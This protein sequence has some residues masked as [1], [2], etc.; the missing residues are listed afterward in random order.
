MSI[1]FLTYKQDI[2]DTYTLHLLASDCNTQLRSVLVPAS[3]IHD[4]KY[5]RLSF[6]KI[7]ESKD[8]TFCISLTV[9]QPKTQTLALALSKENLYEDGV[10]ISDEKPR[11][12]D[13][14][15]RLHYSR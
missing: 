15:L 3:S 2:Q 14:L 13:A 11:L 5:A 9:N 12:D 10:L 8:K 1:I 6:N 4:T 7:T